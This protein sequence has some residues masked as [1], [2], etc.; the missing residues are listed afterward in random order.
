MMYLFIELWR[1]F[2]FLSGE[3]NHPWLSQGGIREFPPR[4]EFS[5]Q[6]PK[7]IPKSWSSVKIFKT[8]KS[9]GSCW[10]IE[11]G[12]DD[13]YREAFNG[14]G[15]FPERIIQAIFR[16][17]VGRKIQWLV[18]KWMEVFEGVS[19]WGYHNIQRGKSSQ[20]LGTDEEIVLRPPTYEKKLVDYEWAL[21]VIIDYLS[22]TMR[23][24][25]K[26]FWSILISRLQVDLSNENLTSPILV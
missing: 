13:T 12:L 1:A 7:T 18:Q 6:A 9:W 26:K 17:R 25:I 23:Y 2:Q 5:E 11:G 19:H 10:N 24:W 4:V 20:Y 8:F 14:S 16:D 3:I 15:D 21:V 22:S